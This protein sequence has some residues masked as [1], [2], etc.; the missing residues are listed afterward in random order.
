MTQRSVSS[1]SQNSLFAL[2]GVEEVRANDVP[3]ELSAASGLTL[4]THL[5]LH[6]PAPRHRSIAKQVSTNQRRTIDR[7]CHDD[8]ALIYFYSYV[9]S[10]GATV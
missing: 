6:A 4:A 7:P 8:T 5:A 10:M 3:R 9:P 1:H 2:I